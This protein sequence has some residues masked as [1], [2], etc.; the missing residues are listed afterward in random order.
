MAYNET[1]NVK[2][3]HHSF[4]TTCPLS[5]KKAYMTSLMALGAT[6]RWPSNKQCVKG[7]TFKGCN[8]FYS[9]LQGV[10][11]CMFIVFYRVGM[12][13]LIMVPSEL[14]SLGLAIGE[15]W[16]EN[17]E[18]TAPCSKLPIWNLFLKEGMK[19]TMC[20]SI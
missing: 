13:W 11:L 6:I 12:V 8:L 17:L 10:F 19:F 1:S 20:P 18:R 15:L 9:C 5:W 16:I 7:K 14:I 4:H 2:V 3:Y